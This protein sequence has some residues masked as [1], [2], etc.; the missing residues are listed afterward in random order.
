MIVKQTNTTGYCD[1]RLYKHEFEQVQRCE[2]EGF[3][4][5]SFVSI[6]NIESTVK[7]Y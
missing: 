4:A 3:K 2:E 7:C 1:S 5:T 6:G